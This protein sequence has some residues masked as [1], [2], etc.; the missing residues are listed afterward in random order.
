M[1]S[2]SQP[3]HVVVFGGSHFRPADP[4]WR[5]AEALGRAV[6]GEGWRLITGGYGGVMEAASK[7]AAEAGG[8]AVGVLCRLFGATGNAFLTRRLVTPDLF[9]RLKQLIDMG[10]GYVVMPG[11]TGTLVELAMVWEL[12]NKRLTSRR[13][14]VCFGSFWSPVV[15]LFGADSTHDPRFRP[16]GLPS[17]KGDFLGRAETVEEV[18]ALLR[19][20]WD[21]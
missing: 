7:G 5:A 20:Q 16:E 13:P 1:R 4:I 15:E 9:S 10:D 14:L 8:E 3:R 21:E 2:A 11:S 12:M 6:A 19:A 17:R 18:V